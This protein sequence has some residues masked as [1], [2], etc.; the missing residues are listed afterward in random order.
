MIQLEWNDLLTGRQ[1][2]KAL[3]DTATALKER[4]DLLDLTIKNIQ[5]ELA[6]QPAF[7]DEIERL[8]I[9]TMNTRSTIKTMERVAHD[10]RS[11]IHAIGLIA[12][13]QLNMIVNEQLS[14]TVKSTRK[15]EERDEIRM[16]QARQW[17]DMIDIIRKLGIS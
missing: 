4:I 10:D 15:T 17:L 8:L 3:K 7:N 6:E 14:K 16:L 13:D 12:V 2:K 9:A 5:R 1:H 11:L